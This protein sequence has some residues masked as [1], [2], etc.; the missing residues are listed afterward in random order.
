MNYRWTIWEPSDEEQVT[1]ARLAEELCISEPAA[2]M[3]VHRGIA[4]ALDARSYIRPSLC[5]LH[6]P[7]LMKDMDK[8]VN[9]L[10]HAIRYQERI[11]V[12]GDYDVDGTT[13][14][15]LMYTFL[16]MLTSNVIYYIPDRYAEGYG[17]SEKG[18]DTAE[19]EHC[20][21]IVALDCGIKAIDKAQYAKQKGIDLIVCD[22]HTPGDTIPDCTAV[23][24]MKRK[25]CDYPYKE[26]SGC[27]VGFKLVQGYAITH[28]ISEE[29]LAH[30][31][32]LLAMSIA[33]DVVPMTGENRI[34]AYFGLEQLNKKPSVGIQA[35]RQLTGIQ[36]KVVTISDLVFKFGP[37]INASGRMRSGLEAVKL[38]ITDDAEFA[39]QQAKEIDSYNTERRNFDEETTQKALE[40]LEADPNNDFL[41]STVVYGAGWHK[42]VIGITAS[43][44]TEKY[45]RP[46]IVLTSSDQEDIISGSARS[47]ADFDIYTAI[48]SCRDLLVN[49]GGHMF[50]A[51]LSMH[52]KD[53]PEFKRRFEQYVSMHIRQDQ[54]APTIQVEQELAFSDITPKFYN[55]L[56]HL[57]PFGPDNPRPVFVTRNVINNR[58]TKTVGKLNEHLRLDVTDR[59]AAIA[60][61][62][63]GHGDKAL[64][65]QNGNPVD[66]CYELEENTFNHTTT[67]QMMV[68]DIKLCSTS[69]KPKVLQEDG[70]VLK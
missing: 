45:Y 49:F 14:V 11:M 58:Y 33:S 31:L 41:R 22:H 21:L 19:Q 9:R 5:N 66:L 26:L 50:A 4:T 30:L 52:L 2:R 38:L 69:E 36:D 63:F 42:G 28:G 70:A 44:L 65:I 27:G 40:I 1:I 12:Y 67:I 48:D 57:E 15:A 64:H 10:E 18:I 7:F 13:A 62:A 24:N 53:L 47:V 37:R 43:R 39:E 3:L 61:I 25:D 59:T 23:L 35:I 20:Q 6:D 17:I 55:I 8:A 54:L 56:K 32:P 60:G 34:L 16:K 51:G 29:Q 68:Q 46:T